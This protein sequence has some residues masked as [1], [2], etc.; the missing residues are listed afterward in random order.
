MDIHTAATEGQLASA[1]NHRCV[2]IHVYVLILPPTNC[3]TPA[4]A[5][6]FAA[7]P[8][9]LPTA[10]ACDRTVRSATSLCCSGPASLWISGA[11]FSAA[12]STGVCCCPWRGIPKMGQR[13]QRRSGRAHRLASCSGQRC[14]VCRHQG[15]GHLEAAQHGGRPLKQLCHACCLVTWVQRRKFSA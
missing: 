6:G 1:K 5:A 13:L 10:D 7:K 15:P 4:F 2:I 8:R 12:H 9:Q 3:G 11:K 14:H